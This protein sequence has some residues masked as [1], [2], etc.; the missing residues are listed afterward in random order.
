VPQYQTPNFDAEMARRHWQIAPDLTFLNHGSFGATPRVVTDA[1]REYVDALE[2]D[3]IGFLAPER[4]LYAK[5]DQVRRVVAQLVNADASDIA[6]VRNATEGVNA[7]L[8][9][10]PLTAGDEILISNHGYNAC[11]NAARQAALRAGAMVRGCEIPFPITGG[12]QVVDA[13]ES[14]IN[15]NTRIVMVDHVTSPT[16]LIFPIDRIAKI[17]RGAG[18]RLLVDGAHAPG[19]VPIDLSALQA[20]YY[21]ANHHKWLCGP[22]ASGFLWV[23]PEWQSE[24]GSPI[25]SHAANRVRQGRSSFLAQFD[26]QGTYDPSPLLAVPAAIDFLSALAEGGL[27]GHMEAN[28][29]LTLAARDRLIGF[30][31]IDAPAPDEMLGSLAAVPLPPLGNGSQSDWDPLQRTLR[32]KYRI[33]VPVYPSPASAS[34]ILRVSMQAYNDLHQIDRLVDALAQELKET[35][36]R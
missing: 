15:R 21:T 28:R 16:G 29:R 12:D 2:S 36:S 3:P 24:V 10:F 14:S 34:R 9:S 26:W 13:I 25:V 4:G 1:Q 35:L 11:N 18:V 32:E 33:E 5:L 27:T 20:D 8:A 19:M 6:F 30:L 7:V 22:K 23:K 17:C 31:G